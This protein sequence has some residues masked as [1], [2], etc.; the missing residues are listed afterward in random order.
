[1]SAVDMDGNAADGL[2][3]FPTASLSLEASGIG[4]YSAGPLSMPRQR[5]PSIASSFH[6]V[7]S[8][9]QSQWFADSPG[10]SAEDQNAYAPCPRGALTPGGDAD[11]FLVAVPGSASAVVRWADLVTLLLD[12]ATTARLP[13][14]HLVLEIAEGIAAHLKRDPGAFPFATSPDRDQ[15]GPSPGQL[16]GSPS[17]GIFPPALLYNNLGGDQGGDLP[18]PHA[19]SAFPTFSES[20]SAPAVQDALPPYSTACVNPVHTVGYGEPGLPSMDDSAALLPT[21]P[22]YLQDSGPFAAFSSGGTLTRSFS[23]QAG[24]PAPASGRPSS[25]RSEGASISSRRGASRQSSGQSPYR[26]PPLI[27]TAHLSASS[28]HEYAGAMASHEHARYVAHPEDGD[29]P[30]TAVPAEMS[31]LTISR[32]PGHAANR[33][34][35]KPLN[36]DEEVYVWSYTRH[37]LTKLDARARPRT[38]GEEILVFPPGSYCKVIVDET[39]ALPCDTRNRVNEWLRGQNC[40][41]G[42]SFRFEGKRPSVIRQHVTTCKSRA[43]VLHIDPLKRFCQ[44]QLDAQTRESR[45]RTSAKMSL[46]IKAPKADDDDAGDRSSIFSFESYE[47]SGGGGGDS[48]R[49]SWYTNDYAS[50]TENSFVDGHEEDLTMTDSEAGPAPQAHGG[51][52]PSVWHPH[53]GLA[54]HTA[55]SGHGGPVGGLPIKQE[56]PHSLPSALENRDAMVGGSSSFLSFED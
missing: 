28:L 46:R 32:R 6:S 11:G 8:S 51:E 34:S 36:R 23:G 47:S 56:M 38:N 27:Q 35:L 16:S 13:A 3:S 31:R 29:E 21:P 20:S 33:R 19:L 7:A 49:T 4:I 26:R 5:R 14:G 50:E 53:A 30:A 24:L 22:N 17:R 37:S 45:I 42:C 15:F 39:E 41:E 1:M 9:T 18:R 25:I 43:Q 12:P 48:R 10:T 52:E 54:A 2:Q 55:W 44:L 40:V